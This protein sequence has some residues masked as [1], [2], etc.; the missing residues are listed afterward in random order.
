MPPDSPEPAAA[1]TNGGAGSS[2]DAGMEGAAEGQPDQAPM[3]AKHAGALQTFVFSA[4]LTLPPQL[5][6]R[7]RKGARLPVIHQ[8]HVRTVAPQ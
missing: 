6:K 3:H 1:H 5:R 2:D 7:L 8:C 4:T